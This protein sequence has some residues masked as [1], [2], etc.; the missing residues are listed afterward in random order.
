MVCVLLVVGL[1]GFVGGCCLVVVL[2]D[3]G[4][5]GF[6]WVV[7]CLF[8]VGG[9]VFG[10]GLCGC[11]YFYFFNCFLCI[12]AVGGWLLVVGLGLLWVVAW[13]CGV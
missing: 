13:F 8:V 3:C 11:Y 9:V 4:F 12:T 10:F 5:A 6:V 7:C 1:S 2:S